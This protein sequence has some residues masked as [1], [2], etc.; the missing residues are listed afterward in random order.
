MRLARYCVVLVGLMLLLGLVV[1]SGWAA[2]TVEEVQ[3]QG[4]PAVMLENDL[5]QLRIRP[6]Q[7][8]RIDRFV[9][10]PTSTMLTGSTEGAVLVDRVWNYANADMSRQWTSAL[11]DYRF[12]G[13]D[14]Q[15][16]VTLRG[17]GTIGV[18]GRMVF[19]KTISITSDSAVVRADYALEIT[20]DAMVPLRAGIWWHN[21]LGVPQEATTYFLPT[22]QG[23]KSVSYGAGDAGQFWWYDM[24]R[25]WGA[26]L[27]ESGTGV[28]AVVDFRKLMCFYQYMSGEVAGLEWAYR[29]EEIKNSE[30]TETTV[31]LVP[32]AGLSAVAGAGVEVVGEVEAPDQVNLQQATDGVP[33][34]VRLAAPQKWSP[35]LRASWQRVPDQQVHEAA[36][37]EAQVGPDAVVEHQLNLSLPQEGTYQLRIEVM[38]GDRL[39]TD[40]LAEMVVGQASGEVAIMP[41]E[42]GLGRLDERFEDKIAVRDTSSEYVPPS[43]DVVTPH[44]K[45]AKPYAG[46]RMK[47]LILNDSTIGRET[48]ELAQRLDMDYI[49]PPGL[50]S[51]NPPELAEF[52]E[53]DYDVILIGGLRADIL[54]E[55]ALDAILA[56]VE[57]GTGLIMVNPNNCSEKLWNVLPFSGFDG[58]ARPKQSWTAVQDHYLTVGIPWE[59]IPPTDTCRYQATGHVLAQ[60]DRYPLLAVSEHGQG[61]IVALAWATSWQA[62]GSY[63]NGLTP[64]IQFA[65][66][67]FA[68]WEY[69]FSILARCMTWAAQKEPSVFI[70]SAATGAEQYMMRDH[71]QPVVELHLSNSGAAGELA[72]QVVVHDRYGH[73]THEASQSFFAATG[74]SQLQIPLPELHGGPHLADILLENAQGEKVNWATVVV[75]MRPSVSI[76]DLEVSDEIYSSG[77]TLEID[78]TL[79]SLADAPEQVALAGMLTDAYGRVVW[80]QEQAVAP[81]GVVHLSFALPEPMAT[82]ALLRVEVSDA[83]GLLDAAEQKLLT[84]PEDWNSRDWGHFPCGMW[85]HKGGAYAREYLQPEMARLLRDACIEAVTNSANWL[86]D[87]EQRSAF[88][89]GLRT[90]PIGVA[91]GV[92]SAGRRPGPPEYPNFAEQREDYL[93]SKDKSTLHRPW[94][95]NADDTREYVRESLE[96]VT[97]AVA[98]YRPLGYCCGDELSVTD[99]TTPF[100]YDFSPGCLEQFRLWLQQQYPS[101]AA[102]NAQWGTSFDSWEQVMP[103]TAEEVAERDNYAPWADH[104]TFMEVTYAEFFRWMHDTLDSYDPGGRIGISGSQAA[105]AYG[106]YDWWRLTQALDFAQAYDHQTTGEMHR[107]FGSMLA[108]PWWG[109][110]STDPTLGHQLW[111]R[112]LNGNTGAM[113][114]GPFLNPDY[115]YSQT[116]LEGTR[117]LEE[118]QSGLARLLG[119]SDRVADVY[120]HYSHPSIHGSF[121]TGGDSLFAANRAGWVKAIEDLGLQMQFLAY[122]QLEQGRLTEIMPRA[123]ILPYSVALSDAEVA[124][125]QRYVEAGGV[126]IADARCGL[127]DAHCSPRS[128][129]ALDGLFGVERTVVDPRARR[130]EAEAKFSTALGQC[131]PRGITL[132]ELSGDTMLRATAG[133]ALGR[134][135]EAPAL[136]VRN[137]GQG[138]AVLLNLFMDSYGRRR[139]LG[140]HQPLRSLVAEMLKLA[141]IT[142]FAQI[143]S[144]EGES[145][146]VTRYDNS[147]ARYVAILREPGETATGGGPG[148]AKSSRQLPTRA[149]VRVRFPASTHLYDLREGRYIGHTDTDK[150][151]LETGQCCIYSLMPYRVDAV[152][153]TPR[154]ASIQAGRALEYRVAIRTDGPDAREHVFRVDVV[155]PDGPCRHY[156]SQFTAEGGVA[157]GVIS[158]ALNDAAGE[159]QIRATDIAT[160]V[161]GVGRFSVKPIDLRTSGQNLAE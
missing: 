52:L 24:A 110:G 41:L 119:E 100:D 117:H 54:S 109:Y 128:V 136:V 56:R 108:A 102:L 105:T 111:R 135:G 25:G 104:R 71:E 137:V 19:H 64:W 83:D 85:G 61:R 139:S 98:R 69:Y 70:T 161:S 13:D 9:Y 73:T 55:E 113:F 159:W 114:Y 158:L 27:G 101:L 1:S 99:H 50:R 88:E 40:L 149:E 146:Y 20:P 46:G 34:I 91:R 157:T 150:Q 131:D 79:E 92:L 130:I 31:W 121:I 97:A 38:D 153:V 144:D 82:T 77:D 62:P 44:V 148:S 65:P 126:L 8:G 76:I 72:A 42:E 45:W 160:G 16:A 59:Q 15:A 112:L 120:M 115:T 94:C 32:F 30:K 14:A 154:R 51:G 58:G 125:L 152:Q 89:V 75:Q 39:A 18:G 122:A 106:G 116:A 63:E 29:S 57:A 96:T 84:M 4:E 78:V 21:R 35:R 129:G 141:D 134:M 142:P 138:K 107:S 151:L 7:G 33:V 93:R 124:E 123:F 132:E 6:T 155:G 143:A 103:M 80:Q 37:W 68:Y 47:A 66:A 60:A 145:F 22:L 12:E 3:V 48:I 43:E 86:H 23:I 17:P 140:V 67:R 90:I 36:V 133:T 26:A 10:K 28:A 49:A 147:Q 2:C 5:V 156:A 11:Y 118:M 53:D 81:D 87:G 127:M 95:L 74:D